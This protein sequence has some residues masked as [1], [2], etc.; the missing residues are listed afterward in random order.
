MGFAWLRHVL[1]FMTT[2]YM[3]SDYSLFTFQSHKPG[4]NKFDNR[5]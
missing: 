1:D 5:P 2:H 4:C 3:N